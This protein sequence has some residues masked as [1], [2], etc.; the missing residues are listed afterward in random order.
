M[1]AVLSSQKFILGPQVAEFERAAAEK[2]GVAHAVGC[3]SGTDALWLALQG[4]GVGAGDAVITTSFSF[5]AT[6]SAI[7]RAGAQ[8]LLVDIDPETFNQPLARPFVRFCRFTS[9]ARP[10]TGT[11]SPD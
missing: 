8:P 6:I 3:S 2:C 5:F 10:P 4:V 9:T 7:L 11:A 1:E